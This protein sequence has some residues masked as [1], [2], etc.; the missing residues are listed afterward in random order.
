[1]TD[2][3]RRIVQIKAQISGLD[4]QIHE[5]LSELSTLEDPGPI[6]D[7]R[8]VFLIMDKDAGVGWNVVDVR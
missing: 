5:L 6:K 7:A 4:A 8:Q 2:T 3:Q 1:M